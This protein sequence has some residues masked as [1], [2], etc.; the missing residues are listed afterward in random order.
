MA[1]C[2]FLVFRFTAA[3]VFGLQLVVDKQFSLTGVN[4][5]SSRFFYVSPSGPMSHIDS[6]ENTGRSVDS[7][8]I[9]ALPPV[10]EPSALLLF[11]TSIG[12]AAWRVW[13]RRRRANRS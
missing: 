12:T 6:F 10:P 9:S 2:P 13:P 5:I 1:T 8:A 7:G 4:A 11:A 3:G